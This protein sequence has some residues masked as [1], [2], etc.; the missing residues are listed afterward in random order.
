MYEKNKDLIL[1]TLFGFIYYAIVIAINKDLTRIPLGEY[2]L[3]PF[4]IAILMGG[5]I[6]RSSQMI[7]WPLCFFFGGTL[8]SL[9]LVFILSIFGLNFSFIKLAYTVSQTFAWFG[10]VSALILVGILIGAFLRASYNLALGSL[11]MPTD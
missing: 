3:T 2:F 9:Q 6:R 10:S 7:E 8:A 11:K 5:S 1:V 4:I